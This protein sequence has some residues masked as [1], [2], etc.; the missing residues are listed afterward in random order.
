MVSNDVPNACRGGLV[1]ADFSVYE[2]DI[3]VSD[4][5]H[6]AICC[7]SPNARVDCCY[8]GL[9]FGGP[10]VPDGVCVDELCAAQAPG[11]TCCR[12]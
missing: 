11:F 10:C 1:S 12:S 5:V 6:E 7:Q 2:C 3:D 9:R 4:H 8:D